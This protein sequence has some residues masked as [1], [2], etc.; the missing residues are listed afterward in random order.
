MWVKS[1]QG[2]CTDVY[3]VTSYLKINCYQ[4]DSLHIPLLNLLQAL[5]CI[6]EMNTLIALSASLLSDRIS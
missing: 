6:P 3:E 1:G 5:L 2:N 4:D